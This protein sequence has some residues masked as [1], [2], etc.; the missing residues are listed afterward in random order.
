MKYYDEAVMKDIRNL[1]EDTILKW[2]DVSAKK[3]FGCPCYKH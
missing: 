2:P 1:V 3:M